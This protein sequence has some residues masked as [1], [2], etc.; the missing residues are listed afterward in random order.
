MIE[1]TKMVLIFI[2]FCLLVFTLI[3]L[4]TLGQ[5]QQELSTT[6]YYFEGKD[7]C[8]CTTYTQYSSIKCGN[9]IYTPKEYE[10]R[11]GVCK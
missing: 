1:T 10:I 9:T 2:G 8:K 5:L 7:H 3:T 11:T 6:S 4:N